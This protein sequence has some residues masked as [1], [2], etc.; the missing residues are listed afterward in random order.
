MSVYSGRFSWHEENSKQRSK[1]NAHRERW[2]KA[3]TD[4][5]R[6][7]L[8]PPALSARPKRMLRRMLETKQLAII[9]DSALPG[10][11][12]GFD[13]RRYTRKSHAD[14]IR[15]LRRYIRED[16]QGM[17]E[18][19]SELL[20]SYLRG[21]GTSRITWALR[22]LERAAFPEEDEHGPPERTGIH[23]F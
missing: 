13:R 9:N 4:S 15:A 11:T 16:C 3:Y 2:G 8:L 21:E 7:R 12:G 1:E 23:R 10:M 14:S 18:E 22:L 6:H 20:R 19:F 17:P 5:V